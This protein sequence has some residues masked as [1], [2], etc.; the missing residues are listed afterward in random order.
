MNNEPPKRRV[1]RTKAKIEEDRLEMIRRANEATQNKINEA[2]LAQSQ[3]E[4]LGKNPV[5]VNTQSLTP[6]LNSIL[7]ITAGTHRGR[8]CQVGRIDPDK[9][10]CYIVIE[11]GGRE[12]IDVKPD[13]FVL[14]GPSRKG[15]VAM[16]TPLP[17]DPQGTPNINENATPF[18][19]AQ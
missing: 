6:E 10:K 7:Q 4:S 11:G 19:G 12:F 8:F 16:P 18:G 9:Y 3:Q 1:R 2:S 5:Y 15:M 14:I 13:E 17:P